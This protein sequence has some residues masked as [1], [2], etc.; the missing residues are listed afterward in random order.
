VFNLYGLKGNN[1]KL[2]WPD[3][4]GRR[5]EIDHLVSRELG[6]DDDIFNLWPEPY[7]GHPWNASAKDR[8]ENR[9][10][11]E[12]CTGNLTLEDAQTEIRFDWRIPYRRYFGEPI[13]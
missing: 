6:G 9:L 5:C 13:R 4:H 12:V 11:K 8:V 1:D 7:G 3:K 2:C 10:H